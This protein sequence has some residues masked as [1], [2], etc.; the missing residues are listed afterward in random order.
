MKKEVG[1]N[2]YF[3]YAKL[4]IDKLH[5]MYLSGRAASLRSGPKFYHKILLK[6]NF[7]KKIFHKFLF[8][9]PKIIVQLYPI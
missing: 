3:F 1:G 4:P 5:A 8:Q 2:A 7:F 9:N 6:S